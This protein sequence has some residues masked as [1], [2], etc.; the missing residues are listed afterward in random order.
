MARKDI[1]QAPALPHWTLR[2]PGFGSL[3]LGSTL[4]MASTRAVKGMSHEQFI[5]SVRDAAITRLSDAERAKVRTVKLTYGIGER[6]L[7]G[8]TYYGAWHNAGC[9][10]C[11]KV[12]LAEI[13]A[14]G[15]ESPTQLAGTTLHEL[16]HVLAGWD[17]GHGKVWK[18][19]CERLGLRHV[20][21]AGT[22]YLL[23]NFAPVVRHA[24][25]AMGIPTDGK[26]L[27]R[28]PSQAVQQPKGVCTQGFG[29][30]GGTSRGAGSGS[31]MLKVTCP[32]CRYVA[33]VAGSWLAK[34]API[35]PVDLIAM[36]A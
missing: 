4:T 32:T 18:E 1:V 36:Q 29:T 19:A 26:P 13:T 9:K 16:G 7:R 20:K 30:R 21:A 35:C 2:F 31:R 3:A 33:R 23:A 27:F 5:H 12:D 17:A 24:I 15:E 11:P 28:D 25:A 6:G 22:N 10:E 34:G 8:V 14:R